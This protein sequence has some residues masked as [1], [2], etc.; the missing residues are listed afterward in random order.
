MSEAIVETLDKVSDMN[1]SI[2]DDIPEDMKEVHRTISD[3]NK[4]QSKIYGYLKNLFNGSD[5]N[6]DEQFKKKVVLL[7][8][9]F[10]RD[11]SALSTTISDKRYFYTLF[12]K[13]NDTAPNYKNMKFEDFVIIENSSKA[14]QDADTNDIVKYAEIYMAHLK[15]NNY[16]KD[17]LKIKDFDN[18][19]FVKKNNLNEFFLNFNALN[20]FQYMSI[21]KLYETKEKQYL[22]N[23]QKYNNL[24]DTFLSH[25]DAFINNNDLKSL[26]G[27]GLW[28]MLKNY[29]GI[30]IIIMLVSL[31]ILMYLAVLINFYYSIY[32]KFVSLDKLNVYESQYFGYDIIYEIGGFYLDLPNLVFLGIYAVFFLMFIPINLLYI[33]EYMRTGNVRILGCSKV[34]IKSID[35]GIYNIMNFYILFIIFNIGYYLYILY[36][37]SSYKIIYDN[38]NSIQDAVYNNVDN[39]LLKFLYEDSEGLN[40]ISD[41]LNHWAYDG[42]QAQNDTRAGNT[43]NVDDMLNKRFKMLITAVIATYYVNNRNKH[44]IIKD[45]NTRIEYNY[46]KSSIFLYSK[47]DTPI[48][49]PF[50]DFKNTDMF[51]A[52]VGP[53]AKLKYKKC[54]EGDTTYF[55]ANKGGFAANIYRM[56]EKDINLLKDKYNKLKTDVNGFVAKIKEND[57]AMSHKMNIILAS[58]FL[59]LYILIIVQVFAWMIWNLSIYTSVMKNLSTFLKLILA[60]IFLVVAL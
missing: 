30:F 1:T 35:A 33:S 19:L 32:Y 28:Y 14:L 31:L 16:G 37:S 6:Y 51:K 4:K 29:W 52:I 53:L 48:L 24:L 13:T 27:T 15:Y 21:K 17:T 18:S 50:M 36:I 42:E 38:H 20:G 23:V 47:K 8:N 59:I 58:I 11:V 54:L 49:P 2:P 45:S 55:C 60:Y 22:E 46:A 57:N 26:A 34:F 43:A 56:S 40:Q 7:F 25:I 44:V 5:K 12:Y 9:D 41:K 10:L 3:I 39:D